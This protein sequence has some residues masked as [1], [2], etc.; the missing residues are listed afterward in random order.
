[1]VEDTGPKESISRA[2]QLVQG[3][4]GQLFNERTGRINAFWGDRYHATAIESGV[5]LLRCIAYIDLNMVRAG[6]VSAP[7]DWR[8]CGYHEI[9]DTRVRDGIIDR[10]RL[11]VLLGCSDLESLRKMH[12]RIIDET[13][14]NNSFDRE[15]RWSESIAV[16]SQSFVNEFATALGKRLKGRTISPA[17]NIWK[18]TFV[19]SEP[20]SGMYYE[21]DSPETTFL[22]GDNLVSIDIDT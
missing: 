4:V 7:M 12:G 14:R 21:G 6:V 19:V 1:M 3:R 18:D 5:H 8:E 2:M 9:H 13:L 15:R 22:A 20:S 17:D 16:G 10:T 11:A